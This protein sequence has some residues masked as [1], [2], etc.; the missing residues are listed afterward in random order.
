VPQPWFVS[1]LAFAAGLI[2]CHGSP[3]SSGAVLSDSGYA[4]GAAPS[5]SGASA[6]PA[7]ECLEPP[8]DSL[9]PFQSYPNNDIIRSITVDGDQVFF[10]NMKDIFSVPLAGGEPTLVSSTRANARPSIWIVG[11]RLVSQSPGESIFLSSPKTGGAWT[12]FLDASKGKG[13]SG[14]PVAYPATSDGSAFYWIENKLQPK[15]APDSWSIRSVAIAGGS[16]RTIFESAGELAELTKVGDRLVFTRVELS[17][18]AENESPAA[19]AKSRSVH[20]TQRGPKTLWSVP[21]SGG[22]SDKIGQI[23]SMGGSEILLAAEPSVYVVGYPEG[24]WTKAGIFRIPSA[25]GGA[26]EAIDGRT[27]NGQGFVYGDRVVMAGQG[28]LNPRAATPASNPY[29]NVGVV[30]LTGPRGGDHLDRTACIRGDY[31]T[32]AYA[33]A[34]K[35]LL[36]AI[37]RDTDHTASIIRIALP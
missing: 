24:D 8:L 34:G 16:A 31:T 22:K 1:T 21:V 29:A 32:H 36:I 19:S 10:R 13:G 30:V 9:M 20:V 15:G 25:G 28:M 18:A 6:G 12:T 14:H 2:A 4:A 27:L 35:W 3:N 5:A 17:P 23:G 11:D 26:L 7:T 37:F 33:V